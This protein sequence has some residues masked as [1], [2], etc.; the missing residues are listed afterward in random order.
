MLVQEEHKKENSRKYFFINIIGFL[1]HRTA[2][3]AFIY[4]FFRKSKIMKIGIGVIFVFFAALQPVIL[5]FL[6]RFQLFYNRY[7]HY[8]WYKSVSNEEVSLLSFKLI[9]YLIAF[10]SLL[11]IN[12]KNNHGRDL[13]KTIN[14]SKRT[15]E[16]HLSTIENIALNLIEIGLVIQIFVSSVI[17]ASY[18]L[19]YYC[20]IGILLFYASIH[21]RIKKSYLK[22]LYII[23]VIIYIGVRLGRIFPF[24]NDLFIYHFLY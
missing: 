1:F 17:G 24:D 22:F 3:L 19:V 16:E 11:I 9:E 20:D 23:V 5:D 10:V 15:A 2:I 8:V 18:R 14:V 6:Q 4:Y 21:Q 7:Y 12:A 13:V